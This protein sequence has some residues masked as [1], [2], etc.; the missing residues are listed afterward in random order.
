MSKAVI[1]VKNLCK[2]YG[3]KAVLN[4]FSLSVE[5]GELV[6]LLGESGCGKTTLLR[7]LAGLEKE[8]SGKVMINGRLME[9]KVSPNKRNIA[10]VFQEPALW[11]H[12]SVGKNIAYGMEKRDDKNIC[13]IMN[14]LGIEGLENRYPEEVSG[15]QAKRVALARALDADRDILFLDEPLSNI[16]EVTKKKILKYIDENYK[17]KKTILYVTHSR[18]EADFF[19]C[20][21]IRMDAGE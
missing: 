12:M 20:R 15:G 9:D 2:S 19:G 11:N 7:I 5:E 3:E 14:A 1:E 4:Q 13:D 18:T 10:M 21:K 17:G 6:V 16:D 8:N